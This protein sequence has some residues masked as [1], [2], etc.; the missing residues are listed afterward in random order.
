MKTTAEIMIEAQGLE[1][2]AEKQRAE[3]RQ[4][5][6]AIRARLAAA[7]AYPFSPDLDDPAS[8]R[9]SPLVGLLTTLPPVVVHA[10]NGM[11]GD[12]QTIRRYRIVREIEVAL[13]SEPSEYRLKEER[14]ELMTAERAVSIFGPYVAMVG[15]SVRG[16]LEE[17]YE[18]NAQDEMMERLFPILDSIDERENNEVTPEEIA[19]VERRLELPSLSAVARLRARAE[20]VDFLDGRLAAGDFI[21]H[22]VDWQGASK[23][24]RETVTERRGIRL[25]MDEP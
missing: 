17:G 10:R 7:Q 11:D 13:D 19:E 16:M 22:V 1:A 21:A 24:E 25:L 20:I 8:G 15:D 23:D 3:F 12:P 4:N 18:R 5:E 9:R 14:F 6:A 2:L